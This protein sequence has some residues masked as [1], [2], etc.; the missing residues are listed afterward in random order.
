MRWAPDRPCPSPAAHPSGLAEPAA[1][2]T[3]L[4]HESLTGAKILMKRA[5]W[6]V[7]AGIGELAQE[8]KWAVARMKDQPG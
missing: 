5:K 4:A 3:D 8:A 6:Q 2:R 1:A 7:K